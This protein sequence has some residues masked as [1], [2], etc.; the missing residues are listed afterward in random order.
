MR[1]S[2][3]HRRVVIALQVQ[4]AALL[5]NVNGPLLKILLFA[6][7]STNNAEVDY[8]AYEAHQRPIYVCYCLVGMECL[9]KVKVGTFSVTKVGLLI[10][11][12]AQPPTW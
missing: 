9:K 12:F 2:I 6:H 3:S 8:V 4:Y 10:H 5:V 11:P 1:R 7:S